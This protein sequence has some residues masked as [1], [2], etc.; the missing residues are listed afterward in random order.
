M[1]FEFLKYKT[2]EEMASVFIKILQ[3]MKHEYWCEVETGSCGRI[4]VV[5]FKDDQYYTWHLKTTL[6]NTVLEQAEK[7]SYFNTLNYCIV[8]PAKSKYR[9]RDFVRAMAN[10]FKLEIVQKARDVMM[11]KKL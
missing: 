9:H 6:S 11:D 7:C 2:E 8:P 5:S 1:S 4:D 10:P 3:A